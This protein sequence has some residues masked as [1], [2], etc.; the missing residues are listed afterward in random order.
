MT[1][2]EH[3]PSREAG[4][5]EDGQGCAQHDSTC[6]DK[7]KKF[8][9]RVHRRI[10]RGQDTAEQARCMTHDG[11]TYQT[12]RQV[13]VRT[14]RGVR[15]VISSCDKRRT[16]RARGPHRCNERGQYTPSRQGA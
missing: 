9:A 10:E 2:D 12:G 5:G 3:I 14:V 16:V 4:E 13:R 6:C 1:H 15:S 8:R 11:Q 7:R